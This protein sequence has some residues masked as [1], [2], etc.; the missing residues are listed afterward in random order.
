MPEMDWQRGFRQ[1]GKQNVDVRFQE[2]KEETLESAWTDPELRKYLRLDLVLYKHA[3]DVFHRQARS[4][5]LL[6]PE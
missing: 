5:G 3:T 4:R 2:L 6:V 1:E